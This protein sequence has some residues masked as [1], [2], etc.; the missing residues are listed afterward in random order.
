MRKK[1]VST[2]DSC[3]NGNSNH[4]LREVEEDSAFL[5]RT[6]TLQ[7]RRTPSF[8]ETLH[9]ERRKPSQAKPIHCPMDS[10]LGNDT[11]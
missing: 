9:L 11:N 7:L 8:K 3:F 6:P 5:K 2:V 10:L 4:F 1:V